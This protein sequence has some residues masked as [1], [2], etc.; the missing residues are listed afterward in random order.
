MIIISL[1]M[2]FQ[3]ESWAPP[4]LT[5]WTCLCLINLSAPGPV[6]LPTTS[7]SHTFPAW[8][9]SQ[10]PTLA[11]PTT[12]S[13]HTSPAWPV[14]QT[15]TPASLYQL[16]PVR[17]FLA[18][19]ILTAHLFQRFAFTD[20]TPFHP[21]VGYTNSLACRRQMHFMILFKSQISSQ[22]VHWRWLLGIQTLVCGKNLLLRFSSQTCNKIMVYWTERNRGGYRF[23]F[24]E[25]F[26]WKKKSFGGVGSGHRIEIFRNKCKSHFLN[27]SMYA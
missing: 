22:L 6:P 19:Y 21:W 3:R 4:C 14:S 13:S 27:A 24:G 15:S 16:W 20:Y 5:P 7:S 2:F 23:T 9:V 11:L 25:R 8:P 26:H 1:S 17:G 12:S 10:T 18:S